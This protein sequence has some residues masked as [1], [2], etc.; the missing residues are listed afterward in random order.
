MVESL[1]KDLYYVNKWNG[2]QILGMDCSDIGKEDTEDNRS[3]KSAV[4]LA[5]DDTSDMFY[6]GFT[7]CFNPHWVQNSRPCSKIHQMAKHLNKDSK[8]WVLYNLSE[9]RAHVLEAYLIKY[10]GKP[11]TKQGSTQ[12]IKGHLLNKRHEKKWERLIE[13]YII[14]HGNH[15]F[16][17][18]WR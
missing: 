13:K 9:E 6:I 3:H 10:S 17:F 1:F 4:Y 15:P 14:Q 11:L 12:L 2:C 5:F 7:E 18:T 8:V 16:S